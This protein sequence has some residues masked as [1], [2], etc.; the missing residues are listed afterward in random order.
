MICFYDFEHDRINFKSIFDLWTLN[1][2]ESAID[3]WDFEAGLLYFTCL[4]MIPIQ[5]CV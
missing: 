2:F 5:S 1:I 3:D 4:S